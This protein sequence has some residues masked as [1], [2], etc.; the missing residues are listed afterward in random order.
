[1]S[2]S[3]V[4]YLLLHDTCTLRTDETTTYRTIALQSYGASEEEDQA[5]RLAT[6]R[7]SR[8][9]KGLRKRSS[10]ALEEL[11]FRTRPVVCLDSSTSIYIRGFFPQQNFA[12]DR[13][14]LNGALPNFS[15][16]GAE[17]L[18][19]DINNERLYRGG[20]RLDPLPHSPRRIAVLSV[21]NDG[22]LLRKKDHRAAM[23]SWEYFEEVE[24]ALKHLDGCAEIRAI[25]KKMAEKGI[26]SV[27]FGYRNCLRSLTFLSPQ[28][29]TRGRAIKISTANS[30]ATIR[31]CHPFISVLQGWLPQLL[32]TMP[33][34]WRSAK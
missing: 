5:W 26:F 30:L 8:K 19:R 32:P 23:Y 13:S 33:H 1:L 20:A 9:R 22:R 21:S 25:T 6:Y 29:F 27:L 31:Q 2:S 7:S 10:V 4:D 15:G 28:V 11:H 24:E 14:T 17:R 18:N 34:T 16:S 3:F 12:S